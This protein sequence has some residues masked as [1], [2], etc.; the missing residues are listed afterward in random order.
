MN[1]LLSDFPIPS[2]EEWKAQFKI[3]LKGDSEELL[4][5]NDDIEEL[6]Y[7]C[8]QHASEVN[9]FPDYSSAI[10][11]SNNWKN[12]GT[13]IVEDEKSANKIALQLLNSGA[14]ALRF[15]LKNNTLDLN[16]LM[17][18]IQVEF[19]SISFT[20]NHIQ[21]FKAIQSFF[22]DEQ[23]ENCSFEIDLVEHSSLRSS[24][25]ELTEHLSVKQQ[26]RF[27]V[28]GYEIQQRGATTW[29]E[30]GFCLST[31]HEYLLMLLEN[32]LSTEK[33]VK[34]IHFNIG[35][36]AN[37]FYEITKVKVLKQL[38]LKIIK[39]Y[40]PSH[41]SFIQSE[42]KGITGFINKSLKDPYTNLLRQTT[43]A[44]SLISGGVNGIIVQPYNL[45]SSEGV[46]ELAQRMA[47][48]IPTIL[49]EE[50]YFDSVQDPQSGSYSIKLLCHLIA[51]KAW[52]YFQKLD[53]LGGIFETN[54]QLK[55]SEDI[56]QKAETRIQRVNS[57]SDAII[58][59]NIFKNPVK[60][61]NS[62]GT[63]ENYLSI[64]QL[65]LEEQLNE[66]TL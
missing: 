17:N 45:Y 60:E 49:K 44:M 32:G 31:A 19:I 30:I 14:D 43:E 51:Q 52:A 25:T 1:K 65:I 36:G 66:A 20:I 6:E 2:L 29:Q 4:S 5:V 22:S 62:W 21:Q 37:Y 18:E 41:N 8:Y 58:G 7:V 15:I 46:T 55:L 64:P 34:C 57:K 12:Y 33:A 10:S 13:V 47:L 40:N 35:V 9:E 38:W 63:F 59:I 24:F 56:S 3:D 26:A 48:N 11:T 16:G 28:N 23:K 42:I 53:E 54:C 27:L 50:S 39:S 61:T